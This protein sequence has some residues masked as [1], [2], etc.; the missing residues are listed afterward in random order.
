MRRFVPLL[1]AERRGEPRVDDRHVISGIVHVLQSGR[2][3]RYA[4]R[5]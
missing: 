4:P 5:E 2:P 1:P 3:W